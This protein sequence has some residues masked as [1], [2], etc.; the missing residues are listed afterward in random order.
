LGAGHYAFTVDGYFETISDDQEYYELSARFRFQGDPLAL[1]PTRGVDSVT[2]HDGT[3][4]ATATR[5]TK[6]TRARFELER[7]S[8]TESSSATNLLAEEVFHRRHLRDAIVLS[9]TF[10]GASVSLIDDSAA[11]PVQPDEPIHV[12]FLG[13]EYRFAGSSIV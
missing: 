11:I 5:P 6:M 9:R 12:G 7:I 3:V 2:C 8:A 4:E 13:D 1:W 10:N